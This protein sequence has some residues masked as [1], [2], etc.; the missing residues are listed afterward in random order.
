[1]DMREAFDSYVL[2]LKPLQVLT[3]YQAW[4]AACEWQKQKDAEI[5][6][7]ERDIIK[8]QGE[9]EYSIG[10]DIVYDSILNQGKDNG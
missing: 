7:K 9:Y 10:A 4:Q 6:A 1:M 2:S 3:P 5:A 8:Q